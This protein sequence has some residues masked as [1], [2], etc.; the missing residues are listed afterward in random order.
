MFPFFRKKEHPP[1]WELKTDGV[2]WRFLFS[3]QTHIVIEER[4]KAE[5]LTRFLCA[6]I[7]TGL[8]LW[9]EF[10]LDEKWYTGLEAVRNGKVYLHGYVNPNLPEHLGIYTISLESGDLLWYEPSLTYYH[11]GPDFLIGYSQESQ[12]RSYFFLDPE[13]GKKKSDQPM[14]EGEAE[15]LRGAFSENEGFLDVKWTEK[16]VDGNPLWPEMVTLISKFESGFDPTAGLDVLDLGEHVVFGFHHKT[17]PKNLCYS[18]AVI[19]S[20]SASLKFRRLLADD[21][22]GQ[23][24]DLFLWKGG[25]LMAV[26]DR[27][28]LVC[29]QV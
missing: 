28:T 26:A 7:R 8:P 27:K 19:D 6:D 13:T 25:L 5:R 24:G 15:K 3:S 22:A 9:R 2:I 11:S 16:L 4:L 14:S 20:R 23:A 12:E 10:T 17:A 1:L 18:L 21:L 29:Y